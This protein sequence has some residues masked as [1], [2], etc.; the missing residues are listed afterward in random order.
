MAYCVAAFKRALIQC[1]VGSVNSSLPLLHVTGTKRAPRALTADMQTP[2]RL[3][4]LFVDMQ[5]AIISTRSLAFWTPARV[6]PAA[7]DWLNVEH[8]E[9]TSRRSQPSLHLLQAP[10]SGSRG[11]LSCQ[12]CYKWIFS[13]A[14]TSCRRFLYSF[15]SPYLSPQWKFISKNWQDNKT[16]QYHYSF[17][18]Y[19][20]KFFFFSFSLNRQNKSISRQNIQFAILYWYKRRW[21][22]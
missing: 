12:Q 3:P 15:H 14:P 20:N 22:K 19:L 5:S 6:H 18:I 1:R 10:Y 16:I 9:L 4:A 17:L 21:R 11:H 7:A 13:H 8:G 2:V